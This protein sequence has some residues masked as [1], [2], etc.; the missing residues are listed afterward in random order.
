MI[1]RLMF[2]WL[3][4]A[5]SWLFT[6][7]GVTRN[8]PSVGLALWPRIRARSMINRFVML[9]RIPFIILANSRGF[10]RSCRL[11]L[12]HTSSIH[13]RTIEM[14]PGWPVRLFHLCGMIKRSVL[15]HTGRSWLAN[16]HPSLGLIF[17]SMISPAASVLFASVL[18]TKS[19]YFFNVLKLRWMIGL[20]SYRSDQI[21]RP[22][23]IH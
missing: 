18:D 5:G 11:E 6:N 16:C 8:Q 10:R 20:P 7:H 21:F 12:S 22:C 4:W 9:F 19:N 14:A 13:K 15:V 1:V 3:F 23:T 17:L 2:F